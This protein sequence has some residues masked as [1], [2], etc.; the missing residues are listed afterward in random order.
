MF[1]GFIASKHLPHFLT[2][3]KIFAKL[4]LGMA[5]LYLLSNYQPTLGFPPIKRNVVHAQVTQP[6]QTQKINV[7]SLPFVAQL[8]HQGYISTYYSA[9][10]PGIDIATFLGDK[11]HPIGEGTVID[12]SYTYW[13]LGQTVT[14]DHGQG[15]QSLYAHMGKVYVK[16]G[17]KVS[18]ND[19][20]G[21]VGLTGNTSGPHTH[22]Q[23]S[24][25]GQTINPLAILPDT[26]PNISVVLASY[27]ATLVA[28]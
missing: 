20:L 2:L 12:T 25:D 22:L 9:F 7:S 24:K 15:Y 8:P 16:D 17:Q 13:G 6:E 5:L 27:S 14:V 28:K 23:I 19:V 21:E 10:H 4:S 1:K 11:I 26:L 3:S 18:S